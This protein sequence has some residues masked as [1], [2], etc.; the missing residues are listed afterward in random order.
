M[1]GRNL[2]A[3]MYLVHEEVHSCWGR[4]SVVG[5]VLSVWEVVSG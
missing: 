2:V 4:Y 1:D 5:E 3:G